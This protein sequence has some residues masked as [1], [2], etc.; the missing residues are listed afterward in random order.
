MPIDYT[1]LGQALGVDAPDPL[2][3]SSGVDPQTGLTFS[4][5]EIAKMRSRLAYGSPMEVFPGTVD[6]A[7]L[8]ILGD[9]GYYPQHG[10]DYTRYQMA[11]EQSSFG[12]FAN[13]MN[14][15]IIGE[16]IGGTIEGVGY[17]LDGRQYADLIRGEEQDF[18]NAFS[19]IGKSLKAWTKE[20]SP[21]A[22]MPDAKD[23]DPGSWAWWMNHFPSV[24]STISLLIPAIGTVRSYRCDW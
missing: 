17:M 20:V 8:R 5:D 14:Q 21:I 4:D 12:Q 9:Q 16:I 15:A 18:G 10:D 24:A 19:D 7:T 23:Y 2:L 1:A 13:S 6:K 22:M 11:R 3:G